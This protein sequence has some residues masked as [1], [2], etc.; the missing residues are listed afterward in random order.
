[1]G[2]LVRVSTA[3]RVN[4]HKWLH[5]QTW[6]HPRDS[7]DY[8][9]IAR[10]ANDHAP[11]RTHRSIYPTDSHSYGPTS[12]NANVHAWPLHG[13]S[14]HSMDNHALLQIVIHSNFHDEPHVY[15]QWHPMGIPDDEP[16]LRRHSVQI[17]SHPNTLSTPYHTPRNAENR[18]H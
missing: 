8:A 13:R 1:M 5:L 16:T 14:K 11:L 6:F 12:I 10:C 15:I 18:A 17:R 2:N 7:H 3:I 9:P 4:V